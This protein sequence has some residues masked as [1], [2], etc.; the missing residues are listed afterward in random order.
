MDSAPATAL[1]E[2][3][4]VRGQQL[5]TALESAWTNTNPIS[6]VQSKLADDKARAEFKYW[7]KATFPANIDKH[8]SN[9][10]PPTDAEACAA[11]LRATTAPPGFVPVVCA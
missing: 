11:M 1:E 2:D 3:V 5:R 8:E 6:F 9:I 7:F 4:D 10:L